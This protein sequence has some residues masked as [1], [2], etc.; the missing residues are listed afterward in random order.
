MY[1]GVVDG[2][3]VLSCNFGMKDTW[4]A[5]AELAFSCVWL[6]VQSTYGPHTCIHTFGGVEEG[7][8]SNFLRTRTLTINYN[9]I[10]LH[11][12]PTPML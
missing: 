6:V 10:T 7:M 12:L 9:P 3:I 8:T 4:F 2:V 1:V 11:N 5:F